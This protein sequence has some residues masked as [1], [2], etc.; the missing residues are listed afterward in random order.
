MKILG[1]KKASFKGMDISWSQNHNIGKLSDEG[2]MMY[3]AS[4]V[5]GVINKT[6]IT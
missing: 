4:T 6:I 3:V 5:S 2:Q 1:T